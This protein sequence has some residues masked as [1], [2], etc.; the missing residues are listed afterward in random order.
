MRYVGRIE[1]DDAV[2]LT[3]NEGREGGREGK[4][5][6]IWVGMGWV[7][8]YIYLVLG[9]DRVCGCLLAWFVCMYVCV[10][11]CINARM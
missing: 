9:M 8:L 2:L 5:R 11:V 4:R 1:G 6:W 7:G 10:Y 3:W